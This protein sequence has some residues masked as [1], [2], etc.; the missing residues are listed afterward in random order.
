PKMSIVFSVPS[1]A[2]VKAVLNQQGISV[3]G[4]RL[5][6]VECTKEE[7]MTIFNRLEINR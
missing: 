3:G 7:E 1:P 5:P 6:L 4:V 2:P